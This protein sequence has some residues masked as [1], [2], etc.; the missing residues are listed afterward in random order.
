MNM[1]ITMIEPTASKAAT[2]A[3]AAVMTRPN[4]MAVDRQAER[5]AKPSSK[6]ASLSRRQKTSVSTDDQRAD[7][8]DARQFRRQA[9]Q[10]HRVEQ[11]VPSLRR[12]AR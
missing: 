10:R 7:H 9:G 3:T 2:A 6:V 5:A 8:R 12:E 4:P 1:A 11:R